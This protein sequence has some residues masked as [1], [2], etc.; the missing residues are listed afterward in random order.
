MYL[1]FILN[2]DTSGELM[3]NKAIKS[4]FKVQIYT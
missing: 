2:N 3:A 1:P 4:L